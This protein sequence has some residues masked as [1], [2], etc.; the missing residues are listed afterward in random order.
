MGGC[1][2]P[3]ARTDF[4]RDKGHAPYLTLERN[5]IISLQLSLPL[6]LAL[7]LDEKLEILGEILFA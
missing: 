3:T 1:T 5:S 4:L 2:S 6:R 7:I